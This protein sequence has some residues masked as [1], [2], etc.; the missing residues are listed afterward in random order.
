MDTGAELTLIF[1]LVRVNQVYCLDQD[2]TEHEQRQTEHDPVAKALQSECDLSEIAKKVI[3][4]KEGRKELRELAE[5]VIDVKA[6]QIRNAGEIVSHDSGRYH[7]IDV[8]N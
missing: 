2:L 4:Y 6:D 5:D 8:E 3:R 7:V 1:R